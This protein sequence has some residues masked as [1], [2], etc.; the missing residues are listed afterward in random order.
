[1]LARFSLLALLAGCDLALGVSGQPDPCPLAKF[2]NPNQDN[3]VEAD[4]FSIDWDQQLAVIQRGGIAYEVTLT[5]KSE[6]LIDLGPYSPASLALA[7]EGGALF[8]AVSI[9]PLTLKGALRRGT[10]EWQLDAEVPRGTFAGTPSADAFGP[11]RVLVRMLSYST[12][13]QEYEVDEHG[14]WETVGEPFDFAGDLAPNLTP[15]GLTMVYSAK[16]SLGQP[17]VYAAS[18]DDVDSPFGKPFLLRAGALQYPQL[19]G[20][21]QQLYA[22]VPNPDLASTNRSVLVR[23]D[24]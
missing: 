20:K 22:L 9:E 1:M 15:N 24:R 13:I 19:C 12:T 11:R 10:A 7:P 21:C 5:D 14:H 16:D 18:R 4:L 2:A 3:V 17:G 23:F 8:Y 6:T